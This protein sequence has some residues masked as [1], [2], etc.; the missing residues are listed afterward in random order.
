MRGCIVKPHGNRKSWGVIISLGK[1]PTTGKLRQKWFGG[2]KTRA[3]AEAHLN[4][5]MPQVQDGTWTP[6]TKERMS[7]FLE[8][9]LRDYA[10]SIVRPTT[11][12]SYE[13]IARKHLVPVLGHIPL[14]RLAPQ[15]IQGYFTR[16]LQGVK[17]DQGK[18]IER[19]LSSTTVR[20]HAMLLHRVME[21]AV[22]WGLILQNPAD[23]VDA[24]RNR[25]VEMQTLDTEQIKIFLGTAKRM[26][27]P[28][29]PLYLA[30]VTTG[31]RVGEL[32]GM[33]WKDVDLP[34][35]T[36]TI[37]QTFYRLGRQ[38]LFG[39]PKSKKSKRTIPL[40]PVFVEELRRVKAHQ[41]ENRRLLGSDYE[42][43]DLIF[44]Q[45][46]GK[47]LHLGN[48][49]RGNFRRI[50]KLAKL[51]GTLRIHDL[52]HTHASVLISLGVHPKVVQERLGHQ[53]P[54]FSMRVYGHL[55]PGIQE[56]AVA[57]MQARLFGEKVSE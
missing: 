54:G 21:T 57:D 32:L 24:P 41:E 39:Q 53:D 37:A 52:R 34:L 7:A 36:A 29:Y 18:W 16:K 22:R 26:E 10:A 1:D 30:L 12:A 35:G 17:N 5:I 46:N 3:E 45:P 50:V 49:R 40:L 28:H 15:V 8:R 56:Q 33:R 11:F 44:C 38:Q 55:L 23:R 31:C 19:P 43:H 13:L 20:H 6:P 47:P 42:D 25:E 51:P 9:W 14:M 4:R 2:F 48:V 27:S